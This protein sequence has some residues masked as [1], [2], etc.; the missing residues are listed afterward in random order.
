MSQLNFGLVGFLHLH[1]VSL[2][3]VQPV[4]IHPVQVLKLLLFPQ[5][6]APVVCLGGFF[7]FGLCLRS[8]DPG[9]AAVK[10][11][12]IAPVPG[13]DS[14]RTVDAIGDEYSSQIGL[15]GGEFFVLRADYLDMDIRCVSIRLSVEDIHPDPSR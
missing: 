5:C 13:Y 7:L 4:Q 14:R 6:I 15:T 10:G 11:V 3:F 2:L 12:A 9:L 8:A 1:S